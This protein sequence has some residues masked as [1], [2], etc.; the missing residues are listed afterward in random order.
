MSCILYTDS[1]FVQRKTNVQISTEQRD[2][3]IITTMSSTGVDLTL[4]P[5]TIIESV[6]GFYG[7]KEL[8][9]ISLIPFNN[10]SVVKGTLTV[11]GVLLSKAENEVVILVQ[12]CQGND[13]CKGMTTLAK[14]TVRNYDFIVTRS[15]S[16]QI[17]EGTI[18]ESISF[19]RSSIS[20][21]PLRRFILDSKTF[22]IATW[23]LVE[24]SSSE[25]LTVEE[26]IDAPYK[27]NTLSRKHYKQQAIIH[28][29]I[30]RTKIREDSIQE[31]S[32]TVVHTTC[33]G[34][35]TYQYCL[36]NRFS[37]DE[38]SFAAYNRDNIP[39][40]Y[41]NITHRKI[42]VTKTV[43]DGVPEI[44]SS[45]TCNE[46]AQSILLN[47]KVKKGMRCLL[48]RHRGIPCH[49]IDC[50]T[51]TNGFKI[52]DEFIEWMMYPET[53]GDTDIS[54]ELKVSYKPCR[55]C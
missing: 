13:I 54:L 33:P 30:T 7:G 14:V 50:K 52:R 46:N 6:S 27:G 1:A 42:F 32:E 44:T 37:F 12:N 28:P 9:T 22:T 21:K 24:N 8:E 23:A 49:E 34:V 3:K 38:D 26:F 31:V 25:T 11:D 51:T 2:G 53:M 55:V 16:Y 35:T 19:R 18:V 29:G 10:V 48:I 45:V 20:W 43:S 39:I 41:G 5:D 47:I 15:S 17:G 4:P 36:D 40:G